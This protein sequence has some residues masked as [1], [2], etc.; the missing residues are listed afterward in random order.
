MTMRKHPLAFLLAAFVALAAPGAA[1][2][3]S[4]PAGSRASGSPLDGRVQWNISFELAFGQNSPYSTRYAA[5]YDL[6]YRTRQAIT[7]EVMN[8]AIRLAAEETGARKLG[9]LYGPG[10]YLAFPPEASGQ[11]QVLATENQVRDM[12][13]ILGYLAQQTEVWGYRSA[14][15]GEKPALEIL[16]VGGRSL[17][18]AALVERFWSR[19][20]RLSP[21]LH[22]GFSPVADGRDT[23]IRILDSERTWD[24]NDVCDFDGVVRRLAS[25]HRLRL[26]TRRS[27]FEVLIEANDWKEAPEGSQYL[28][29]LTRRGREPLT[30]RLRS[31]YQA[32]M[33]RRIEAALRRA[34]LVAKAPRR[35]APQ[36]FGTRPFVVDSLTAPR[37]DERAGLTAVIGALPEE[38]ELLQRRMVATRRISIQGLGFLTGQLHGRNVV[39]VR[40]GYGKVNAAAAVSLL[41]RRFRP[42]EVI[43]T[44][45]AGAIRPDLRLG[46]VLLGERSLQ[47]DHGTID[48][49]GM[50][51][52][53]TE[54]P[55]SGQQN[56]LYYPGD[57]ALLTLAEEAAG[58]IQL[59]APNPDNAPRS[60]T[61]SRGIIV[62]GD[63]FIASEAKREQLRR[64]LGADAVEMEGAV[65]AQ[66]CWQQKTPCLIIRSVSDLAGAG[67]DEDFSRFVRAAAEN[68]A[69]LVGEIVR[70]LGPGSSAG[71]LRPLEQRPN[72]AVP[73]SNR[74][75]VRRRPAPAPSRRSAGSRRS[76]TRSVR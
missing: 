17:L 75:G 3:P 42:R 74:A 67:A 2:A 68:S 34:Q 27:N 71:R 16:Q 43:F 32:E 14:R 59:R 11:L 56:P 49:S 47:H 20:A 73:G 61:V 4:P 40:S 72:P 35:A 60:P 18:D 13:A 65:V 26:R 15:E 46:D 51:V 41:L 54:D 57:T 33:G 66:V 7:T 70:G 48:E 30:Q 5:Y 44:G 58:R 50:K 10:G 23:G 29:S 62:T 64:D 52:Q 25:E 53:P 24:A 37:T 55:V 63:V 39:V 28:E 38:V 1:A 8:Q 19:L 22:L 69:A 31:R 6:P 21:K 12:L 9:L 45:V 76:R 36:Q